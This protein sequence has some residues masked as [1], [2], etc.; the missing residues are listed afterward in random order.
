MCGILDH[1][2][3]STHRVVA[4]VVALG[5]LKPRFAMLQLGFAAGFVARQILRR[6]DAQ[7]FPRRL[8]LP[9]G[10]QWDVIL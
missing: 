9:K 6:H 2:R 10:L 1:A 3:L 4:G 8:A 5:C 7:L